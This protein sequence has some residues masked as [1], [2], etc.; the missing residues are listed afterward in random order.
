MGNK[1][2]EV[3]IAKNDNLVNFDIT[4]RTSTTAD[5]HKSFSYKEKTKDG[6]IVLKTV[7]EPALVAIFEKVDY[8]TQVSDASRKALCLELAG[9]NAEMLKKAGIKGGF[10]GFIEKCFGVKLDANTAGRYRKVGVVFGTRDDNGRAVWKA[11][12]SA[13]VSVSN[14]DV[15]LPLVNLPKNWEDLSA[16]EIDSLYDDF[17]G[18]YI[19]TGLIS[20]DATQKEL[21][22]QKHDL[23]NMVEGVASEIDN[24]ITSDKT[25]TTDETV[26]IDETVSSDKTVT[27]D[28]C[29]EYVDALMVHFKGNEK[30]LELL[31]QIAELLK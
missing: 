27:I 8:L 23:F 31:A 2:S 30:A 11:P 10:N 24:S 12:I 29:V 17:V 9:I 20:L 14:L 16:K 22:R 6:E 18:K 15:V 5:G 28:N 7:Y 13:D 21:K 25:V 19:V 1:K 3:A 4:V 26:T